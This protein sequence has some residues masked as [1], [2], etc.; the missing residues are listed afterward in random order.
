[1]LL[2]NPE[3]RRHRRY[4]SRTQ[5]VEIREPHTESVGS[6]RHSR[7]NLHGSSG[8]KSDGTNASS[9]GCGAR[10]AWKA[11]R[12]PA[13]LGDRPLQSPLHVLHAGKRLSLVAA[14]PPVEL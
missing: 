14:R 9:V 4:S 1:M 3:G 12:K 5:G 13:S 6:R 8:L 2:L 10:R 11:A 7:W